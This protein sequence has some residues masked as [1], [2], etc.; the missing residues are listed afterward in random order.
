MKL[1]RQRM[2]SAFRSLSKQLGLTNIELAEGI[3]AVTNAGMER[4]VRVISVQRGFDPGEFTLFSFGGAGGL[5]AA[6]LAQMLGI[7]RVLAPRHPGILSAMGM[8]LSD[9]IL[10]DSLTVMLPGDTP[11]DHIRSLLGPLE[12]RGRSALLKEGVAPGDITL[13]PFL[14]MRYQGQ[15]FELMVPFTEEYIP[16]FH[17]L[18]EQTYGF[19]ES[20]RAVEIVNLRLRARGRSDKPDFPELP[21][22]GPE[23][24]EAAVIGRTQVC[25]DGKWRNALVLDRE[26]LLAKNRFQGPALLTEY[27]STIIVPPFAEGRVDEYGNIIMEVIK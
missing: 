10:D 24:P 4:A 27:S 21:R 7:P 6:D 25:F 20:G 12:A 5:H 11:H 16:R 13:E 1:D 18:H 17:D 26:K 8:L 22:G 19:S 2:D 14:D 15:S 9:I 3:L 23:P